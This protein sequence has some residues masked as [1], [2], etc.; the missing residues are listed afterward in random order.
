MI[1]D[2]HQFISLGRNDLPIGRFDF[3]TVTSVARNASLDGDGRAIFG[4]II[5][6]GTAV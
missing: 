3:E 6:I 2:G 1:A 4:R 5:G